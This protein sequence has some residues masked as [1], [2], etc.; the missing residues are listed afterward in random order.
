[1]Q[2][3]NHARAELLRYREKYIKEHNGNTDLEDFFD[4]NIYKELVKEG[5]FVDPRDIPFIL[6]TDG[7]MIFKKYD[8][9]SD[10]N[11]NVINLV[12]FLGNRIVGLSC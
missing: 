4:G 5:Y 11:L 1:M 10:H 6:S 9:T 8:N 3:N 2:Y 12:Y 7:F